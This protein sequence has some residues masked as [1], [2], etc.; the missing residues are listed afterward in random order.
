MATSLDGLEII[1]LD[2]EAQALDFKT[3]A[4]GKALV[5]DFWHTKCVKCPA[6]LSKLNE[7]AGTG[8]ANVL[9]VAC[10]LSQGP[11]NFDLAKEMVEE[12][13]WGN[14]THVFMEVDVKEKA[15]AAFG[16]T[17]VP[18]VVVVNADGVVVGHGDPK[19]L[20]YAALLSKA[21]S[22]GAGALVLDEDF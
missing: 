3:L 19:N 15:K 17:A 21:P 18:F 14:L 22:T 13:E 2:A 5:L 6:A 4:G 16:F 10:A 7:T 11:G 8:D 12:S 20:D 9:Y 1:K